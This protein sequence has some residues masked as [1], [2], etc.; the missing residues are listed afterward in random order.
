MPA[1]R[2]V[3]DNKTLLMGESPIQLSSNVLPQSLALVPAL[4]HCYTRAEAGR[5]SQGAT[6]GALL[7][8]PPTAA[9]HADDQGPRETTGGKRLGMM[10]ALH[11][12]EKQRVREKG[13]VFVPP[14]CVPTETSWHI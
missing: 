6:K 11:Q 7:L 10:L 5:R 3:T 4:R 9:P 12:D 1:L 2:D 8:G 13:G 14:E